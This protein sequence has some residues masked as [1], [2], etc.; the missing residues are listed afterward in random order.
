VPI[1]WYMLEL[2]WF[3]FMLIWYDM[4]ACEYMSKCV[5]VLDAIYVKV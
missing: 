1:W 3:E 5:F 4:V 2:L